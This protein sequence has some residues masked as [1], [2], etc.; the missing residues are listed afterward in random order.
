[1]TSELQQDYFAAKMGIDTVCR[2]C[3]KKIRY[4][5]EPD[6]YWLHITPDDFQNCPCY[7]QSPWVCQGP[8]N[9]KQIEELFK[10]LNV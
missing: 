5:S 3:G 7:N 1:M 9:D 4:V 6:G 8:A 10:D 2:D